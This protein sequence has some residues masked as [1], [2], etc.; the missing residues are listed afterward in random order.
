MIQ[1]LRALPALLPGL[2]V[3]VIFAGCTGTTRTAEKTA[4][5]PRSAD[6]DLVRDDRITAMTA[7]DL[8][9]Q[10]RDGELS[11]EQVAAAH[12]ERIARLN[13]GLNAIIEINPDALAIARRLDARRRA[14][15]PLGDLFGLPVILKANIDTADQMATS[16]GSL[17]LKDHHASADAHLVSLLRQADALVLA[18]ANLSEWANFRST[19]STSGWSSLGGQTRNPFRPSHNPCGSS[20]GSAV[21]VAARFAPLAVGTETDGSIVCPAAHAGVV[22]LKP[23][24]GRISR[25]GIIPIAWSQDTAG[26]MARNARDAALLMRAMDGYDPRDVTTKTLGKKYPIIEPTLQSSLD[27]RIGVWRGYPGADRYPELERLLDQQVEKLRSMGAE[28]VDPI[29]MEVGNLG[30]LSDQV[31][32]YEF[33]DGL[34]RYLAGTD[35]PAAMRS[36]EG[37]IRFNQDHAAQVMPHFGQ[38]IFLAAQAKGD[39]TSIEYQQ[40]LAE[41]RRRANLQVAGALGRHQLEAIIS[42]TNNPAWPIDYESGDRFEVSSS[43]LPAISGHPHLTLPMGTV[44]GFPVGL[45]IMAHRNSEHRAL[46]IAHMLESV[47]EPAPAPALP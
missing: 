22:G 1:N 5:S 8:R 28:V 6:A 41:A 26:P 17:A 35:L 43:T 45:S 13:P 34:N 44:D 25:I 20:S 4:P 38:D 21:A 36:L 33:K 3:V 11:V 12:L 23:T 9:D 29:E 39:L 18:K 2:I 40:A 47:N 27:I 46:R 30:A 31:L 19:R 16:A 42:V 32:L 10:M 24:L 37:L 15:A 14:G 7:H